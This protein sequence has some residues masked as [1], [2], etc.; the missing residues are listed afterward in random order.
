MFLGFS[1]SNSSGPLI[2]EHTP[3]ARILS[4]ENVKN[5]LRWACLLAA[6]PAP[7]NLQGSEEASYSAAFSTMAGGQERSPGRDTKNWPPFLSDKESEILFEIAVKICNF[8]F[9]IQ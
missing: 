5:T 3:D 2:F 8:S 9:I 7:L 4:N 1:E 6:P